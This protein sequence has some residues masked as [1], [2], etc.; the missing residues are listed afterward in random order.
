MAAAS[1]IHAI[2]LSGGSA[3]GLNAATGVM[4]YLEEQGIGFE[5]RIAKVPLVV[6]SCIFDLGCGDDVRPDAAMAM[7]LAM[8]PLM[9]NSAKA[10]T[11]PGQGRPSENS[12]VL[13]I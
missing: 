8:P 4:T 10:A 1:G 9:V 5:T 2:L 12:A 11:E 13:T 6:A 7:P 3:F